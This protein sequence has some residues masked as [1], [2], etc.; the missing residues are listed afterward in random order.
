MSNEELC[1]FVKSRLEV[2]DDLEKVCNWVVDT[3]LYKGSHDILV[4]QPPDPILCRPDLK[5]TLILF[6]E[7]WGYL[8]IFHIR[9]HMDK[10]WVTSYFL[11]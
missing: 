3:C 2:S 4:I 8:K 7:I 1:E 9:I 11:Q 5:P 10:Y 6:Q